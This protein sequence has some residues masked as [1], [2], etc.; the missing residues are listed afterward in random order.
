M[1]HA[2]R[3]LATALF[4]IMALAPVLTAGDTARASLS[5]KR[6]AIKLL[7]G[8]AGRTLKQHAT[9]TAP[10]RRPAMDIRGTL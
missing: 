5:G 8:E 2:G 7:A 3:N 10:R 9:R 1:T 4:C 6:T